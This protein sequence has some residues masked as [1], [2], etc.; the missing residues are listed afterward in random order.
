M[1]LI[2]V[3]DDNKYKRSGTHICSHVTQANEIADSSHHFF[4]GSSCS[5]G[6]VTNVYQCFREG[7]IKI[8]HLAKVYWEM[9]RRAR[10]HLITTGAPT[11]QRH[12]YPFGVDPT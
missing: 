11:W 8:G 2:N 4:L 1:S 6:P 5:D 9:L 12:I 7:S 3:V 10:A